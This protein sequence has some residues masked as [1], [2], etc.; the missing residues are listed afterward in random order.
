MA[1][2]PRYGRG[3]TQLRASVHIRRRA[4][5]PRD[6][7]TAISMRGEHGGVALHRHARCQF[8]LA[9][10]IRISI[11]SPF[12]DVASTLLSAMRIATTGLSNI[13]GTTDCALGR[14]LRGFSL[15]FS[16]RRG[17]R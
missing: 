8:S 6:T 11:G 14:E 15:A 5:L 3:M 10:A 17:L 13:R 2:V 12:T 16:L 4:A 1:S 9:A 7:T